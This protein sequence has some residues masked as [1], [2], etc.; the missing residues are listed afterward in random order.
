MRPTLRRLITRIIAIV[1]ASAVII[2]RGD[3]GSYELLILSQVVLSMQLPFAVIPLIKF[4]SDKERMGVFVNNRWI[5][6]LAWIAAI[7]IVALNLRLVFGTIIHW[8]ENAGDM[9]MIIWC[10]VVP[11]IMGLILF[12]L[13]ISLPKNW[14]R[15]EPAMPSEIEQLEIV[16]H[17]FTNIGVALDLSNM[18]SKVLSQAKALAQQNG[19]R[20]V[21]M[22]VVEGVGGQLFGK[23]AYDDEARDDLAHVENHAEQLRTIGLE[24]QA[25]LGFG[26]IPKEIVRIANEQKIDLLVMGGHGH[27]GIKDIIFG[28]SISRVRHELKIPLLVV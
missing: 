3:K 13:Y 15:R 6:I 14:R 12:L 20:L 27:R 19:A 24:V 9:A 7:I 10:I 1:P 22:H 18:D 4:T 21:L 2:F 5:K 16:H 11:I 17:P 8:I 23:N 25:V 28:T 26:R